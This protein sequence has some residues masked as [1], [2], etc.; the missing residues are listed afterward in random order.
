MLNATNAMLDG[1]KEACGSWGRV[2]RWHL[3]SNGEGYPTLATFERAREGELD[4]KAVGRL[5]QRFGEVFMGDA[6]A[7]A[8]AIRRDPM[9]PESLH[10]VLFVHY[11]IPPRNAQGEM[12]PIRVKAQELQYASRR[13]YYSDLENAYHF[14]LGRVAFPTVGAMGARCA[15]PTAVPT[16]QNAEEIGV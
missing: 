8:L 15:T 9:M 10:R 13:E 7:I 6:Q 1:V 11:V 12:I 14:L 3:S 4:A 2:M 16:S 5:Q